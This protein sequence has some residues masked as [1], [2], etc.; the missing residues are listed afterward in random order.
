MRSAPEMREDSEIWECARSLLPKAKA[1]TFNQALM[2]LGAT[3]CT[4][5]RPFCESCPVAEF[6]M[7]RSTVHRGK[8]GLRKPERSRDGIPNRIYRGRIVEELRGEEGSLS[9]A[10]L[11]KRVG[12]HLRSNSSPWFESLLVGLQKDGLIRIRG[13]GSAGGKRVSLA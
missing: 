6:C 8:L 11:H 9:V 12:G 10:V 7:S 3:I 13:N 4:A 1:Y 5:R 2:D